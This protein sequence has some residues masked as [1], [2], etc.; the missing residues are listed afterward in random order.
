MSADG[1]TMLPSDEAFAV[2]ERKLGWS[3]LD[4]GELWRYRELL[5]F[6]T[7]RDILVRYKQAVIGI[8]WAAL[9]PL[10]TMVVFTVVFNMALGIKSPAS[11]IPYAVFSFTGLL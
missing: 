4:L 9:Q 2:Y 1:R 3:A 7:W 6:L 8:A 5:Y 10:L 11:A